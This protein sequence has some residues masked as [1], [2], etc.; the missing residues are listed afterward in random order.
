MAS[1]RSDLPPWMFSEF[2]PVGVDLDSAEAVERYDRNQ[3]THSGSDDALLDRLGVTEGTT[4]VDLGTGTGSLPVLAAQRGARV[5]AVDVSANMLAFTERRAARAGVTLEV[6]EAGFLSYEH[7]GSP[8]DVVTTRSALHQLPDCW[9]QVAITKIAS[10]LDTGG[11]FYLQDA[12][13]SFPAS[14]TLE[15]LPAWIDAVAKAPGEGFT[16]EDFETHVREEFSTFHW[17]L[18]GMI[19]RAGLAIE[20]SSY[21]APWYGEIRARKP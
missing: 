1:M 19:E 10:M 20:E 21:P 8:A 2:Q 18:E 4:F 3:G 17:I 9:K 5:H 15:Q 13:W 16:R 6:H 12:M 14:E 11:I 7:R